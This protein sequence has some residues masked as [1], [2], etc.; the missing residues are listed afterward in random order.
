MIFIDHATID[1]MLFF[2]PPKNRSNKVKSATCSS[3]IEK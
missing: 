2:P 1:N 3:E